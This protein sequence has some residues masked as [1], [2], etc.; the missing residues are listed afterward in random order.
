MVEQSVHPAVGYRAFEDDETLKMS[1]QERN[2]RNNRV[3]HRHLER[4]EHQFQIFQG[5]R[6]WRLL[7]KV[8]IESEEISP[9]RRR[10]YSAAIRRL[11]IHKAFKSFTQKSSDGA[12]VMTR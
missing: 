4:V 11:W 1:G 5:E 2:P 9:Q 8:A 12:I 6:T 7:N 10:E 3:S